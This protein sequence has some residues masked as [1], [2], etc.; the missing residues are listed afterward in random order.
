MAMVVM[1]RSKKCSEVLEEKERG[2]GAHT[3]NS[4]DGDWRRSRLLETMA[5]RAWM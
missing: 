3:G 1:K 4:H 5:P 2:D